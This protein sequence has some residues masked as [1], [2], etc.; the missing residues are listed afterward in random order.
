MRS[1]Y[2]FGIRKNHD[3]LLP[4]CGPGSGPCSVGLYNSNNMLPTGA[5]CVF[6]C[7]GWDA[8]STPYRGLSWLDIPV[9][10][11]FVAVRKLVEKQPINTKF[12]VF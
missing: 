1:V 5:H 9:D 12:Y 11:M 7:Y 4:C 10:I 3:T 8:Q 6:V 2:C